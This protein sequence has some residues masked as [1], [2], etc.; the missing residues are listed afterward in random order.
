MAKRTGVHSVFLLI[1][2]GTKHREELSSQPDY[3]ADNIYET[4]LWIKYKEMLNGEN[5]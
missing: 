1:G 2:H 4:A 5:A 3:I